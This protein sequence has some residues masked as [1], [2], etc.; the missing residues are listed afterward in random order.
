MSKQHKQYN[1]DGTKM[2]WSDYIVNFGGHRLQ[3][4]GPW[5]SKEP[6]LGWW[7]KCVDCVKSAGVF[8][9]AELD[10]LYM[11]GNIEEP[12]NAVKIKENSG[13]P[14]EGEGGKYNRGTYWDA[15]YGIGE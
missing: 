4:I 3:I 9:D 6:E 2:D 5:K 8:T 12:E 11:S 1:R 7:W 14:K 10:K 15:M 13:H